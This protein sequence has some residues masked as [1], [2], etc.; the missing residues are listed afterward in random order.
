MQCPIKMCQ[1][2][3]NNNVR[4]YQ[5]FLTNI[6]NIT[7]MKKSDHEMEYVKIWIYSDSSGS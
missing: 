4:V 5:G 3:I 6:L 2:S 7:I 1:F